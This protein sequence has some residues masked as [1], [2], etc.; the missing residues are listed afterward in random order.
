VNYNPDATCPRWLR[1]VTEVFP[2]EPELQGFYQRFLGYALTGEVKEHA[3]GVWYGPQGR[4]GK[5]TT[6]RTMQ[7][8]F[9][10]EMVREVPFET[11]EN[12]R[13]KEVHTELIASLRDARLVVGQEGN[14]GTPMN[15]ALLKNWS[16]GDRISARHL[17]GREFT[18]APKFT[19]V[20]ATNHLPQF[21]SGGNALWARTKAVLFGQNF[22]DRKDAEL[23]P[24]IQGPEAEG[25]AAWVIRGAMEYYRGG[26]QDPL[27][28]IAATEYH[29]DSVDPLKELVGE[30]FDYSDMHRTERSNFNAA[31]KEWREI[32]GDRSGKW[33]PSAV[34][35]QLLNSGKVREIRPKGMGWVYEG[36][37]L[38][39]D[40]EQPMV[41]GKRASDSDASR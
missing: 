22:N 2:D 9:G 35:R 23:E 4:N 32:N 27:A 34:K 37:R 31:L 24:T 36:I 10:N 41:I 25:V 12:V 40:P 13:G 29:K 15:T 33:S 38:M 20:L 3:L 17:Y 5:G 1:F 19:L 11:F 30:L 28:V 7:A 26:L 39:S 18:Y 8:C 6:I 14:E 16:G 21:S